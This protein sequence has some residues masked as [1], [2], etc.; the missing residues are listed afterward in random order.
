MAQCA[1][2]VAAALLL[3]ASSRSEWW[4][5]GSGGIPTVLPTYSVGKAI[6][7]EAIASFF[8]IF[9]VFG[10]SVD[11]RGP[12]RMTAGLTSGWWSRST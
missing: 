1:G 5:S 3:K 10:T 12:F 2:A 8:L 4:S 7:I 11:D 9:A 6:L